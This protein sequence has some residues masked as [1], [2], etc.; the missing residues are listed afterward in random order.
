MISIGKKELRSLTVS[1]VG[2]LY[3]AAALF[4]F[5]IY[6]YVINLYQGMAHVSYAFASCV[7][8]FMVTIPV[9][10]MRSFAQE[11]HDRTDQLLFTSP[12]SPA[13]IVLGKYL[14]M[15]TVFLIPV[16]PAAC[17]PLILTS[18]GDVALTESYTTLLAY[19]LYGFAA[20]AVGMFISSFTKS[21][22]IAA[23][24][25]AVVLFALHTVGGLGE[26]MGVPFLTKLL[27]AFDMQERFLAMETGVLSLRSILYFLS[28]AAGGIL[29]TVL[30][31]KWLQGSLTGR[32]FLRR[33]LPVV[34]VLVGL[35]LLNVGAELL[36]DS[37]TE[38]DLAIRDYQ[39][40]TE[41][42]K[43]LLRDLQADVKV[44]VYGREETTD[45]NVVKMLKNYCEDPHITAEYV[46]PQLSPEFTRT[47]AE[48]GLDEGSLVVVSGERY[49][50]VSAGGIYTYSDES[51]K[52]YGIAPD[53]FD[54]EGQLTSAIDYVTRSSISRVY[55]VTGH[56]ELLLEGGF[57]QIVT[58]ENVD[59]MTLSIVS[60]GQIP[61]DAQCLFILAPDED[62]SEE[63]IGAIRDY[64]NKGGNLY[65]LLKWREEPKERL[66]GLLA[67]YGIHALQGIVSETD[68]EIYFQEPYYLIPE[69]QST[70]VTENVAGNL[71]LSVLTVGIQADNPDIQVILETG[72]TAFLKKDPHTSET[73]EWEAGDEKGKYILGLSLERTVDVTADQTEGAATVTKKSRI[74]V[75]GSPFMTQDSIDA[76]ISGV[77]R[78]LFADI[79]SKLVNHPVRIAVPPKSY[80]YQYVTVSLAD[81]R[82]FGIILSGVL[83]GLILI[84]G[85]ILVL[86]R[87]RR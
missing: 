51:M 23:V 75:F 44:Y 4:L 17:Y 14:A 16:V 87:R 2:V 43:M 48:N 30:R 55:Q 63:E 8:L 22:V 82:F 12:V 27:N 76:Y 69:I 70:S 61:E 50:T 40:L 80:A 37:A 86:V 71:A 21:N 36:P 45:V 49:R 3:V 20:I 78:K 73:S 60:A 53:G 19:I 85:A 10:T 9:L 15:V 7:T 58:R 59:L 81:A 54:L 24:V 67:E 65:V 42:T 1:F 32:T 83:P 62:Y 25:T 47:Y 5:G 57:Q 68:T 84:A 46:D 66:N 79:F 26:M 34:A 64:L 39:Q 77:N 31:L 56:G 38:H 28:V 72:E 74:V 52:E 41:Q 11:F 29:L 18:F 35:V 13:R 33:G 6:F